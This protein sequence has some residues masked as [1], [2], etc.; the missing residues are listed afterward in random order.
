MYAVVADLPHP[1]RIDNDPIKSAIFPRLL[2][3]TEGSALRRRR[4]SCRGHPAAPECRTGATL[5]PS[6]AYEFIDDLGTETGL[7]QRPPGTLTAGQIHFRALRIGWP[8]QMRGIACFNC[9]LLSITQ[10]MYFTISCLTSGG[11]GYRAGRSAAVPRQI[12]QTEADPESRGSSRWP[13]LGHRPGV[14]WRFGSPFHPSVTFRR[15][16]GP[17]RTAIYQSRL[18]AG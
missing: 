5:E 13:A 18:T 4:R 15:G 9:A 14:D 1:V 17:S 3:T 11:L 8:A 6:L 7:R 10:A 12:G 2:T 16:A